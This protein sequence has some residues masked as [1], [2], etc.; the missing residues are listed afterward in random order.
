M[1]YAVAASN[2]VIRSRAAA[3]EQAGIPLSVI[4][5]PE[6][7]QRNIA[8]L[9]EPEGAGVVVLS[10]NGAGGLLTVTFN[11]DLYLARHIDVAAHRLEEGDPEQRQQLFGRV[12][13]EVLRS[14]DY[15][16]RQ[17]PFIPIKRLVIAPLARP[18]GL[19][20]YLADRLDRPVETLDLGSVFDFSRIPELR[21][22]VLQSRCFLAL[23]AALRFE[24]KPS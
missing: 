19:T 5:I 6:L 24:E 2:D 12:E 9:L 18:V 8:A 4:D 22:G 16:E 13:L 11:G 23:G 21:H 15:C 20:E 7:A 14:L 10:F 3:M 1:V 17:L